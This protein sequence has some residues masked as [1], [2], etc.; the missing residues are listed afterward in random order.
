MSSR[1]LL[2]QKPTELGCLSLHI[3]AHQKM[4]PTCCDSD[5][6]SPCHLLQKH[7][8]AIL[9]RKKKKSN[10]GGALKTTIQRQ[11]GEAMR[12]RE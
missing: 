7:I 1:L 9:R 10:G 3:R 4:L 6:R 12:Y 5:K 2:V 11:A 8:V